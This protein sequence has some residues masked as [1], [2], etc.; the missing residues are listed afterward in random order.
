MATSKAESLII[1]G[2][3]HIPDVEIFLNTAGNV[4][5]KE[6]EDDQGLLFVITSS[7][8]KEMKKFID[9]QFKNK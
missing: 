8:W 1:H 2:D 6:F 3:K 5:I 4:C 7:D 9:Q